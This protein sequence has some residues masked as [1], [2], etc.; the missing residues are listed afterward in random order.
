MVIVFSSSIFFSEIYFS[1]FLNGVDKYPEFLTNFIPITPPDSNLPNQ[2]YFGK[3]SA[4]SSFTG[5]I[6]DLITGHGARIMITP[7]SI[8]YCQLSI[9]IENLICLYCNSLAYS[10]NG[11]CVLTCPQGSYVDSTTKACRFCS[12]LCKECTGPQDSACISCK[13]P[14]PYLFGSRC[15]SNCPFG[16]ISSSDNT[17]S[18]DPSCQECTYDSTSSMVLCQNCLN[19]SHFIK[20]GYL[21]VDSNYCPYNYF[22]NQVASHSC[23]LTCPLGTFQNFA[24][25]VCTSYCTTRSIKFFDSFTQACYNEC[26]ASYFNSTITA[27]SG[28]QN[29]QTI[30]QCSSC[31]SPCLTCNQAH[32]LTCIPGYLYYENNGTC[33]TICTDGYFQEAMICRVCRDNCSICPYNFYLYN[34]TCLDSCPIGTTQLNSSCINNNYAIVNILNKTNG[35]TLTVTRQNNLNLL[36]DY[37]YI[38]GDIDSITWSLYGI[39]SIYSSEFFS[40]AYTNLKTLSI[41][42]INLR[43]NIQYNVSVSVSVKGNNRQDHILIKTYPDIDIGVFLLSPSSGVSGIDTFTVS[44]LLWN[45]SQN[46]S[47]SLFSYN[48]VVVNLSQNQTI[49]G[50][51]NPEL[52]FDNISTNGNYS[53]VPRAILDTSNITFELVVSNFDTTYRKNITVLLSPYNGDPQLKSDLW[54]V[55]YTAL[56]TLNDIYSTAYSLF[57]VYGVAYSKSYQK[58]LAIAVYKAAKQL[59]QNSSYYCNDLIHC[60]GNGVCQQNSINSKTYSCKCFNGFAGEN[61]YWD[62]RDYQL[63]TNYTMTLML[64]LRNINI[65][66]I[67]TLTYLKCLKTFLDLKDLLPKNGIILAIISLQNI[68][69]LENLSLESLILVVENIG[70]C[71]YHLFLST[72]FQLVEQKKYTKVINKLMDNCLNKTE[73]KLV[74]G[75]DYFISS[76]FVDIFLS[77]KPKFS[78]LSSSMNSDSYFIIALS[79]IHFYI[80]NEALSIEDIVTVRAIQW[81]TNFEDISSN[82]YDI[83]FK[84]EIQLKFANIITP[85]ENLTNPILIYMSKTV[86]YEPIIDINDGKIPYSCGYFDEDLYEFS[87]EG[88]QFM[89][90]SNS[91]ILCNCSH[92]STF[93]A[94]IIKENITYP[95]SLSTLINDNNLES[96]NVSI[97][98]LLKIDFVENLLSNRY[99]P[100]SKAIFHFLFN[101]ITYK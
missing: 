50:K 23:S 101:I 47:I 37:I 31:V 22:G 89:N 53:F 90:E 58:D 11:S 60:H 98:S 75:Q 9:G 49:F 18:C 1:L 64:N 52:I 29:D 15:F 19:P 10:Y 78:L 13:T 74:I 82:D 59:N 76:K 68:L 55:N 83:S 77:K 97:S 92:F 84:G 96:S 72:S 30:F 61:C 81:K 5:N 44:L 12:P 14:S 46:L 48:K 54:R 33:N 2:F 27:T 99:T 40:S 100:S 93:S 51:Y 66:T 67:S 69:K 36:V 41:P 65:S 20:D 86:N 70:L 35:D 17:C 3:I 26:P 28:F 24:E 94:Q 42:K 4:D 21:C 32:C 88:C 80:P 91:F 63:L 45:T 85:I 62:S 79:K 6:I 43:G 8:P 25:R 73:A 7:P 16:S 56:I 71:N 57:I 38:E 95:P 39:S 34:N 87:K